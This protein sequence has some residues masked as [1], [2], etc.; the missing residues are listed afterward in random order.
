MFYDLSIWIQFCFE[1]ALFLDSFSILWFSFLDLSILIRCDL[2]LFFIVFNFHLAA[3]SVES[4]VG[5]FFENCFCENGETNS[6]SL[7]FLFT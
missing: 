4:D 3:C 2:F 1:L 6:R 7:H 5:I